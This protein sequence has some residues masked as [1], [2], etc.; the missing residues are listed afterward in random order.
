[1]APEQARHSNMDVDYVVTYRFSDPEMPDKEQAIS[2]Y[3]KLVQ[4]LAGVGLST[5]VR[6]GE[7]HSLLIFVRPESEQ[8]LFAE[9]YRSRTKDWLH[10]VRS[11]APEKESEIS[12]QNQLLYE[13]ERLRIIY[14]LITNP[15]EEGGAGITPQHGDWKHVESIFTLH[16]EAFNKRWLK[17][18]ATK[19][20]L[21]MEDLDEIRDRLGE[22]VA[23]YFA[24]TQF[25]FTTLIGIAAFGASAYFLLGFFSPIYAIVNAVVCLVFVEWWRHQEYDLAVRWGVRGV[26][27]IENKRHD[28]RPEKVFTDP[29]TGEKIAFFPSGKRLTR[30]LLQVPFAL[31]AAAALGALI[32]FAFSIEIFM[33]EIYSGPGQSIL[34]FL[35]TGI[36][37]TI[38]PLL[39]GFLSSLASKLNDFENHET[40]LAHETAYTQKIFIL[41]F[42]TSYLP[43]LLTAFVYVPF[44]TDLV[45][46]LDVFSLTV[47]PFA[48][49]AKET[50]VPQA[51]SFKI[52]PGR[53]RKQVIYF[54]VTA[55]IVNQAT[56]ILV[57]YLKRRGFASYKSY[58][59]KKA[60]QAGT[61]QTTPASPTAADPPEEQ[62]FLQRVRNEAELDKYEVTDDLREMVV[63]YGYLSLFSCV[64]PLTAVSFLVN[65]WFELRT[66][67][68]K[69]C[70]EV[71]RPIPWRADSIGPWLDSLG[72]LTWAGSLTTSALVYMFNGQESIG[73][74]GRPDTIKASGLLLSI[75]ASEN[76][77]FL[78]RAVVKYAITK[79][80]S[81][82]RSQERAER[83]LV[84]KRYLEESRGEQAAKIAPKLVKSFEEKPITRQSLEDEAREASIHGTNPTMRF[85]ARQK[86]WQESSKYGATLIQRAAMA[87][88]KKAQ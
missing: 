71:Q 81:P 19:Y 85:W 34:V 44:A 56:E 36:L 55:Q 20:T 86:G 17:E 9:V 78:A 16:D 88:G 21:K 64:W 8:N 10:G 37:T 48:T 18:W 39:L 83:Y 31:L 87:E 27:A 66:D 70:N 45:P 43:I 57:P 12:G 50:A 52:N 14:Q 7:N 58:K 67:A 35:P 61:A 28:F 51:G 65:N 22:K 74:G 41:N 60:A 40:D 80:D 11:A 38:Q 53:L 3:D 63:Q 76:V 68:A 69:I 79:I 2:Q 73:P 1:M 49:D 5:E 62:E 54:V 29:A 26:T 24:F 72:F 75:L 4:A 77:Y 23:F 46:Y 59:S 82:G 42:I 33:S 47:E 25:Y 13:A 15:V 84:R 30:Q 32:A 6:N